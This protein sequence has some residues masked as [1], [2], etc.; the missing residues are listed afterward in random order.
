MN[1][2]NHLETSMSEKNSKT[3]NSG[4][5]SNVSHTQLAFM[6]DMAKYANEL[7]VNVN[8]VTDESNKK[9]YFYV[10]LSLTEKKCIVTSS[11]HV[12][13]HCPINTKTNAQKVADRLNQKYYHL[14]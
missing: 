8:P 11:I 14:Y 5:D 7:G 2:I 6:Q 3:E 12:I 4:N 13:N 10:V 9:A 1:G